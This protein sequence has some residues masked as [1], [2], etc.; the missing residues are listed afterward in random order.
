MNLVPNKQL[1]P[2]VPFQFT[3]YKKE[4]CGWT[5]KY[6]TLFEMCVVQH[7]EMKNVFKFQPIKQL[8]ST[9]VKSAKPAATF[10]VFLLRTKSRHL[11]CLAVMVHIV[12]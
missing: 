11:C 8:V 6:K 9:T 7:V 5:T 2:N 1:L 3:K 12:L 10:G 4:N